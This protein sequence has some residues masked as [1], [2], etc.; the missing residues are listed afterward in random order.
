MTRAEDG[1]YELVLE[2]RH[3]LG[4]FFV[5][6]LLCGVFF[7]LGY[8]V[9]KS[10]GAAAPPQQQAVTAPS[11]EGRQS[12]MPPPARKAESAPASEQPVEIKQPPAGEQAATAPAA[13]PPAE[14]ITL[15]VAALSKKEDADA[16][17][18]VLK[19]KSFPVSISA[20]AGDRLYHVLVG[21]YESTKDADAAKMLLEKEGFR[22]IVKR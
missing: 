14:T 1:E 3:V 8:M 15:Q 6:A 18:A 16:M 10:T 4:I 2:N 13:N 7:A 20:G 5:A 21:P 17:A 19:E 11:G 12:P 9:G 22:A